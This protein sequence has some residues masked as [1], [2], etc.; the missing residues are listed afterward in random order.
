M[1]VMRSCSWLVVLVACSQP[2]APPPVYGDPYAYAPPAGG[3]QYLCT[4]LATATT[5]GSLCFASLARCEEER[6]RAAGDGAAAQ[7]CRPQS[8][9]ACFQRQ[10]DPNPANEMCAASVEDCELLRLIDKDKNGVTG[11]ACAYGHGP[12]LR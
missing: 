12:G 10:N 6:Q 11:A 8:P 2:D 9:V 4:D 3:G 7:P 5:R 1:G